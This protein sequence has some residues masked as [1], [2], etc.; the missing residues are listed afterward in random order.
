MKPAKAGFLLPDSQ[1]ISLCSQFV[2]NEIKKGLAISLD[3]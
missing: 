1:K 3:P 2:V